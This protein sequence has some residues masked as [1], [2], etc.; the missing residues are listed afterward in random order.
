MLSDA[1]PNPFLVKP[2]KYSCFDLIRKALLTI[3]TQI[4]DNNVKGLDPLY[5]A[6]Y[7]DIGIQ[8]PIIIDTEWITRLKEA[9]LY[10]TIFENK[11]LWEI[12]LQ[13]GYYLHAI[14]QLKFAADGTDRFVL[15]FRQLGQKK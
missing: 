12:F 13:I 6:D 9:Q 4:I 8:Y 10:E 14:P 1:Q 5:D 11:N 2:Q 7:K 3:D 15:S